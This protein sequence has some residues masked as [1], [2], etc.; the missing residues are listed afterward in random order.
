MHCRNKL[1][2]FVMKCKNN[3]CIPVVNGRRSGRTGHGQA[4]EMTVHRTVTTASTFFPTSIKIWNR[5][6]VGTTELNFSRFSSFLIG[7][8]FTHLLQ[9]MSFAVHNVKYCCPVLFRDFM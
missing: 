3:E 1:H 9:E 5:F 2:Y 8:N 7:E 6:P 4:V